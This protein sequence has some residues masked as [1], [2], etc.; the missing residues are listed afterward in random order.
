MGGN[1][2][3]SLCS[4]TN[5]PITTT[6]NNNNINNKKATFAGRREFRGFRRATSGSGGDLSPDWTTSIPAA[7]LSAASLSAASLS[8]ASLSAASHP[9]FA[10]DADVPRQRL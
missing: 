1:D 4:K 10:N 3:F 5:K 2:K 9:V 6:K 7:S 8:A